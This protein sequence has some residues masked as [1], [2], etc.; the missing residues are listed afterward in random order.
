[1]DDRYTYRGSVTTPPCMESV[2]WNV[3]KT[4]YPIKQRH[5]DQFKAQLNRKKGLLKTGNWRIILP[6]T[7]S[8]APV[9]VEKSGRAGMLV[10]IIILAIAVFG[11]LVLVV[12]MRMKMKNI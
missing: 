11:L 9:I 6:E 5:L 4:V 2:Y 8:H 3:M 10:A 7:A 12:H 1:M